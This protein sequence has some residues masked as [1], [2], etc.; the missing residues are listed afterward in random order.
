MPDLPSTTTI[1]V[2]VA[3]LAVGTYVFRIGG[4]A[5]RARFAGSAGM[6]SVVDRAAVI[7]LVAVMAT[8]GFTEGDGVA[9]I[10]RPAAVGVACLLAWQR[11]P[12]VIVVL[13][14]TA[15]AAVLRALGV[16]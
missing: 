2:G 13:A 6:D 9:G 15:T 7:L 12:F 4:A 10:A 14:A 1:L 5:L 3:L 16:V 8:T 11:C